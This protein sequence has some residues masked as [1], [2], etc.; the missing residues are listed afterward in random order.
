[1]LPLLLGRLRLAFGGDKRAR[2]CI[3]PFSRS[4]TRAA[5]ALATP[6]SGSSSATAVSKTM[7]LS[8]LGHQLHHIRLAP[9]PRALAIAALLGAAVDPAR[10]TA[11][12]R[13][14]FT[15]S[16]FGTG[17]AYPR[18]LYGSPVSRSSSRRPTA[19]PPQMPAPMPVCPL[20][21]SES[22]RFEEDVC[23]APACELG[24]LLQPGSL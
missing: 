6:S 15:A 9:C 11:R 3:R 8:A 23:G 16:C 14:R 10:A 2:L 12:A 18:V 21:P 22:C 5:P 7:P 13:G 1:V 20:P 19:L 24:S 4:T 17:G